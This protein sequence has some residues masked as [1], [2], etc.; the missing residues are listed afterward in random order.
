MFQGVK[1]LVVK[2]WV[3]Y[4]KNI[5]CLQL[6]NGRVV[7]VPIEVIDN[8][9]LTPWDTLRWAAM[10]TK[11]LAPIER[12]WLDLTARILYEQQKYMP[13]KIK[14]KHFTA[15]YMDDLA[16]EAAFH[17]ASKMASKALQKKNPTVVKASYKKPRPRTIYLVDIGDG[18]LVPRALI[19]D[20]FL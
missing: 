11:G 15:I 6:P 8:H 9:Y 16:E 19:D 1:D 13:S 14:G 5:W 7:V 2:S 20:L 18:M 4:D 10:H 3:E 17:T 12:D